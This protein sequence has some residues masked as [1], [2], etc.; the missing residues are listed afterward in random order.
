MFRV[1]SVTPLPMKDRKSS[2]VVSLFVHVH[3][4]VV[5]TLFEICILYNDVYQ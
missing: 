1:N 2:L 5:I 3:L 4:H